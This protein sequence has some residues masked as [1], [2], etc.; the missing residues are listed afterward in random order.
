MI[1]FGHQFEYLNKFSL[2]DFNVLMVKIEEEPSC[3]IG[4]KR[5]VIGTE[6]S[7]SKPYIQ[8]Y[9][10]KYDEVLSFPITICHPDGEYF[11][12][13]EVS[14]ITAWLTSPKTH[15]LLKV[16]EQCDDN[17]TDYV[18][19]MALFTDIEAQVVAGE[20][21]GLKCTVSCNAP[22]GYSPEITVKGV[23]DNGSLTIDVLNNTT[24][25]GEYIYPLLSI[26]PDNS[27]ETIT[28]TN[29]TDDNN[30]VVYKHVNKFTQ[31][32]IDSLTEMVTD[33]NGDLISF[34]SLG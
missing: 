21:A 4:L 6:L 11:T 2:E 24:E 29:I 9:T 7:V 1:E 34:A 3:P 22:Y 17:D 12:R 31:I 32:N 23:V 8:A 16:F 26:T 27:T 14:D 25:L 33:E 18:E 19:Y 10:T 20:V 28:I 15:Q 5:T 30:S 13:Q